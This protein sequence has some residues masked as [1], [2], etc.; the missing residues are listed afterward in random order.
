M[1]WAEG[2]G[3]ST[4]LNISAK[5]GVNVLKGCGLHFWLIILKSLNTQQN[6]KI[7]H[8]LWENTSKKIS[9]K[10]LLTKVYMKLLQLNNEKM[11]SP[12]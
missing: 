2:L 5:F 9:N 10:R 12:V 6:E 4:S 3:K 7:G 8:K 11:R 1:T